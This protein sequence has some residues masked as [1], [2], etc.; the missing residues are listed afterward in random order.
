MYTNKN[1]AQ[2][3]DPRR[4]CQNLKMQP[5]APHQSMDIDQEDDPA[6]VDENKPRIIANKDKMHDFGPKDPQTQVGNTRTKAKPPYENLFYKRDNQNDLYTMMEKSIS[7]SNIKNALKNL[8][9][10]ILIKPRAEKSSQE[11]PTEPHDAGGPRPGRQEHA[12]DHRHGH[13]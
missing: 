10:C 9:L 4:I 3:K 6:L 13:R 12:R 8:N 5:K 7:Q 11:D 2:Q 1:L